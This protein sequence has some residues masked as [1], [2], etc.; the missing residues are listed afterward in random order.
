MFVYKYIFEVQILSSELGVIGDLIPPVHSLMLSYSLSVYH[1]KLDW[2]YG[3]RCRSCLPHDVIVQINLLDF[4]I[5][6]RTG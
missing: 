3:R 5:G 6:G 2:L 1:V 4:Q